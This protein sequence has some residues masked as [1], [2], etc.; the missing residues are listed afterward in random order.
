MAARRLV[1]G[2]LVARGLAAGRLATGSGAEAA[3]DCRATLRVVATLRIVERPAVAKWWWQKDWTRPWVISFIF[4][5]AVLIATRSHSGLRPPR[6]TG[7]G[8]RLAMGRQ[9]K[10]LS[11]HPLL[12]QS[13]KV[14]DDLRD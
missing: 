10:S 7:G 6:W 1:A 9:R 5:G 12:V 11:D 2:R 14:A 3:S 8:R 4:I 13:L